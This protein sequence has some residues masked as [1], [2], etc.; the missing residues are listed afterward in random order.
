VRRLR[1]LLIALVVIVLTAGAALAARALPEAAADGLARA[2]DRSGNDV[3]VGLQ[4]PT[5]SDEEGDEDGEEPDA[6]VPPDA[7]EVD[8]EP[9][10]A[11][12]LVSLDER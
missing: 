2:T 6:A 9:G 10:E 7:E 3:P 1:S 5:V 12:V 11:R 8:G 4:V